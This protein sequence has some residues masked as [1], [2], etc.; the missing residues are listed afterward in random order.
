MSS[1]WGRIDETGT[2]YVKTADGEREVGSWQAGDAEA[3]LAYYQRKFADLEAEVELLSSR[4]ESGAGDAK[5]SKSQAMTLHAS[6]PTAAGIGDFGALDARLVAL[7]SAADAKIGEQSLAREAA[8]SEAIAKKESLAVEAEQIAESSTQWKASGDRLRTIVDEWKL[9]KGI[10]RK[11]DDALWKRFAAARDAF[12]KRR[13]SHF[14]HLDTEREAAKSEKEK[15]VKQAEE[16]ASSDDWRDTATALKDLM[17][18]WKAA[19][20]ANRATE[21][22]LWKRFRAA[23]DAFFERR[24]GVFAERDAEQAQNLKEKEAIIAEAAGLDLGNPRQAQISLRDL[25]ERLET[26]GH[27]PRDAMRRTEDRMRAAEQRVRD[28]LDAEWKRGAAESNPFLA[29]LR[30][31]LTE[32]EAKLERARSS[33][34]VDRIAK[35]EADVAQRRA[36]LPD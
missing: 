5:S 1:E 22:A 24:S 33:G 28:A 29:Q 31:R 11:T 17:T 32:A 3:G 9:I 19:P 12:S 16:L 13:G 30:E 2:V 35:A 20:R 8:R 10:D 23:Q 7:I 14:A 25:Q 18:Q 4:L 21:G 6:L 36:L 27:V 26:I 34:D 15:L